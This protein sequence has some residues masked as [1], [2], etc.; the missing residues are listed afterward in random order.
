MTNITQ[1]LYCLLHP[2]H[3]FF[4]VYFKIRIWIRLHN[5]T[6]LCHFL[7]NVS[8]CPLS[9]SY[10]VLYRTNLFDMHIAKSTPGLNGFIF[11]SG[12]RCSNNNDSWTRT[13]WRP[14]RISANHLELYQ[15]LSYSQGRESARHQSERKS[16]SVPYKHPR[17]IRSHGILL[18][19]TTDGG[20]HLLPGPLQAVPQVFWPTA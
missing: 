9:T 12:F 6:H 3:N 7:T 14:V 5:C 10:E 18:S 15:P 8:S 17:C 1:T 20:Q 4:S 19:R 16:S 13:N 11:I 2:A